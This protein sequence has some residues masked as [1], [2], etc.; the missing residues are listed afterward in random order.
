[1]RHSRPFPLAVLLL[2]L[3][4]APL[5]A[6]QPPSYA[7]QVKPFFARYC[8]ECHSG[9]EA[10]GGLVLDTYKGLFAGGDHGAVL[11]PGKPDDSRL[12]RMVEHKTR[13]RG[14]DRL[15]D[16]GQLG[17]PHVEGSQRSG[18]GLWPFLFQEARSLTESPLEVA[19]H[20]V[21]AGL[22]SH[23]GVIQEPAAF[24]RRPFHENEVIRR[25]HA[26]T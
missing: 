17:V 14:G 1:M 19:P 26:H 5:P 11:T 7:R 16:L 18:I 24:P 6:Q 9:Q 10:E 15:A 20:P 8:A 21:V 25:E 23:Q 12:V 22:E 3:A 13:P 2:G 4:V